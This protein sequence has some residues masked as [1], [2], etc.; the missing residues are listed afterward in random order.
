MEPVFQAKIEMDGNL[1]ATFLSEQN[2]PR[3]LQQ[4]VATLQW[5]C[6]AEFQ[7]VLTNNLI[8]DQI[9]SL[10]IPYRNFVERLLKLGLFDLEQYRAANNLI[11]YFTSYNTKGNKS[12]ANWTQVMKSITNDMCEG[13]NKS[14]RS[15]SYKFLV[16]I[17]KARSISHGEACFLLAGGQLSY[18]TLPVYKCSV[19][20]VDL[21]ELTDTNASRHN[22]LKWYN[23]VHKYKE[24][25]ASMFHLSL[26]LFAANHYVKKNG[27]F[28][29]IV[30]Q[31]FGYESKLAWPLEEDYSKCVLLLY[32]SWL[33]DIES[34]KIDGSYVT[35]LKAFLSAPD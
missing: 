13:E 7:Q 1:Q 31:L 16:D 6:N 24:R 20:S 18:N 14:L 35:A 19:S 3:V 30:P 32:Q 11:R 25:D 26:Y 12:S 5:G 28:V 15:V 34:M 8:Y 2:H 23:I 10:G 21:E 27:S 9:V 22:S 29:Q 4:P 17:G 33:G